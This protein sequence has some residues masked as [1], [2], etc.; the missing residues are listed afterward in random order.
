[1]QEGRENKPHIGFFGRCNTGKST[2]VNLLIGQQ[3]AIVSSQKGTTTD[4]VKKTMELFNVGA[5]VLVDT[6][7]IDDNSILA[8]QR[9]EKTNKAV[10]LVDLAVIVISD[11]QIGNEEKQ[12]TD[13]F[14]KKK[15]P[16]IFIYNKNNIFPINKETIIKLDNYNTD[17]III[18]STDKDAKISLTKALAKAM[19]GI[20]NENDSILKG[21][22]NENDLVLLVTPIDSSAPKGRMI[23]PQVKIIREV[24]DNNAINIVIKET[25]LE[26]TLKSLNQKPKLIITDSQVFD[27]VNKIIPKDIEL[28]SFSVLLAKEKGCFEQYI[29]GTPTLDNLEDGDKIL[30][31]ESCSH[32]PTCEDI[33]RVKL[34]KLIKKYS[35]KNIEC[36]IIAGITDLADDPES[37]KLV[38]QCGGCVA[39]EKQLHNRLQPFIDKNIAVSNYGLA[40]A[41]MNGIFDRVTKIFNK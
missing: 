16:Y 33:G 26:K 2:L 34:P 21:I 8:Q 23:L 35:G 32:Q 25:Q 18:G 1:M 27:F 9:V 22:V 17:Y 28:T 7:G 4:I 38:I 40:I 5:V 13:V 39:T 41:Y 3:I 24:I 14:A 30:M 15:I 6:A 20:I 11:N 37:Y 36:K 29:K 10:N 31:L 19:K 12:L